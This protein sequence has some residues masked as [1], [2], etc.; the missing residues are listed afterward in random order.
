MIIQP[1]QNMRFAFLNFF[2]APEDSI[3]IFFL[4]LI[5]KQL[6]VF[7]KDA[8]YIVEST[9]VF[10][11]VDKCQ[12]HSQA[13]AQ[14]FINTAPLADAPMFVREVNEDKYT[15]KETVL[16]NASCTTNCLAP[17]AKIIYEKFGIIGALMTT[18]NSYNLI[19]E[20]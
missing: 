10:T 20:Q 9:G 5:D 15:E 14:K 12:S 4:I 17:L 3:C 18:V 13:S 2:L 1:K 19:K 6:I 16:S 8:E 7:F 11:T